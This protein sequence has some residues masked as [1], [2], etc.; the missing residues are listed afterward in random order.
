MQFD[1]R[2]LGL[3]LLSTLL[4]GALAGAGLAAVTTPSVEPVVCASTIRV[5]VMTERVRPE[6]VIVARVAR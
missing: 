2:F 1:G 4:A 6:S 5:G 3:M